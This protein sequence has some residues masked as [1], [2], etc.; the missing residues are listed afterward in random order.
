MNISEWKNNF[1]NININN[2]I[3]NL[4]INFFANY[5]STSSL[6]FFKLDNSLNS[7][8]NNINNYKPITIAMDIEFQQAIIHKDGKYITSKNIMNHIQRNGLN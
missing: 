4:L 7:A 3:K 6:D 5:H 1:D 2:N 8:L